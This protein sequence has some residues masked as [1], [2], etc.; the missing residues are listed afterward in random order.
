MGRRYVC[1]CV[2]VRPSV[3]FTRLHFSVIGRALLWANVCVCVCVCI[4]MYD[5]NEA[6][7]LIFPGTAAPGLDWCVTQAGTLKGREAWTDVVLRVDQ[8]GLYDEK[9][10]I[11]IQASLMHYKDRL[12][13]HRLLFLIAGNTGVFF[14]T[15]QNR[16]CFYSLFF[17]TSLLLLFL[18]CFLI[19]PISHHSV[20]P[21]QH[22][23]PLS[24][25]PPFFCPPPPLA[26]PFFAF[27]D[28]Q[29][30]H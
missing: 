15:D 8:M 26:L 27:K 24:P 19:I 29:M 14:V 30:W 6:F 2:S 9:S 7:W 16:L 23:S 1:V 17:N 20:S 22:A 5:A 21:S 28:L 11:P 13:I 3:C 10:I 4:A 18:V 12:F 25:H